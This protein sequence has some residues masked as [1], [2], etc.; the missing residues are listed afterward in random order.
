MTYNIKHIFS[1]V[2]IDFKA[3]NKSVQEWHTILGTLI[4]E[5]IG[6]FLMQSNYFC[7]MTYIDILTA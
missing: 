4:Y 7:I 1:V 2:Y 5:Y 6:T 3:L